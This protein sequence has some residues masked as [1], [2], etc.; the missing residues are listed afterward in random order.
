MDN[1]QKAIKQIVN[2]H[3]VFQLRFRQTETG[4]IQELGH[5]SQRINWDFIGLTD[6][7]YY[8]LS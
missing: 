2:K 1:C 7:P 3:S 4:W 6:T 5:S 8:E